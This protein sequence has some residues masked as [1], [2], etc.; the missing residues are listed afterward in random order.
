[1]IKVLDKDWGIFDTNYKTS[2]EKLFLIFPYRANFEELKQLLFESKTD[3]IFDTRFTDIL[4]RFPISM[5]D[6]EF[7]KLLQIFLVENWHH[8]HES[9]IRKFQDW[10]NEDKDTIKYLMQAFHSPPEFYKYD[11]AL[12]YPY[13]R[14]II[15]AIGAQPE[16]Y[17]F[18]A[19]EAISQSEDE[20][21]KALALHQIEKRKRLGRWEANSNE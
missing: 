4:W 7:M 11:E 19:L 1:M 13:I 9:I 21:I 2:R 3:S 17:N 14:K 6:C 10:F 8:N 12:K 20:E 5:S 15:Y 16:P 18:E